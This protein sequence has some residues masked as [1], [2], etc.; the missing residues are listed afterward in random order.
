MLL[1]RRAWKLAAAASLSRKA[2]RWLPRIAVFTLLTPVV[3]QWIIAY[4]V[5]SDVRLLP[6]QLQSAKNLLV[7][8]AHPDDEC[9]FFA[10]SIL[11]VLDSNRGVKGGLLAISTGNNYGIGKLREKELV[12][13]CSA[14]GIDSSRCTALDTA[15]LQDDPKTW[16]DTELIQSIVRQ[17]VEEWEVDAVSFTARSSHRL[18]SNLCHRFSRLTL[19]VFRD[20]STIAQSAPPLGKTAIH[21]ISRCLRAGNGGEWFLI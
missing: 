11:A 5:G 9:L 6:G 7:V 10:P 13:S 3:L 14:L 4:V 17:Y 2:R 19:K 16:W 15:Q 21:A 18:V 12:A 8:T 1:L 20:T